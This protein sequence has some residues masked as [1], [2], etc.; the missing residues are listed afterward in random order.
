MENKLDFEKMKLLVDESWREPLRGFFE[1]EDCWKISQEL[2]KNKGRFTPEKGETIWRCFKET[3]L[4]EMHTV[5]LALSPYPQRG[6][7]DGLCFSN[8]LSTTESPS[9]KIIFDAIED[10]LGYKDT[11]NKDLKRWANSG[12]LMLNCS[13]T[14][15]IGEPNSHL[16]LYKPL[17]N[18]LYKE[19]FSKK[20]LNFVYFGAVARA[21]QILENG[22]LHKSLAVEHPSFSSREK[23]PMIHKNLF[24]WCNDRLKEQGKKGVQWQEYAEKLPFPEMEKQVYEE[25]I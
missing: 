8:S 24:S 7:S 12:V 13:L 21:F 2:K 14:C 23:R 17:I 25:F 1:S 22:K 5:W 10:N 9:L 11:R 16:E 19:V 15:I 3:K 6:I 20:E 4:D 18:Y